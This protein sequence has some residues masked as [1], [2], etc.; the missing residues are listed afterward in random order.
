MQLSWLTSGGALRATIMPATTG[1]SSI[2]GLQ[3]M[4]NVPLT[5]AAHHE[6][7][8]FTREGLNM[9]ITAQ[10]ASLQLE[11]VGTLNCKLM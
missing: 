4:R 2:S 10:G 11:K 7:A 3:T 8:S 6:S 9:G 1:I 5:C